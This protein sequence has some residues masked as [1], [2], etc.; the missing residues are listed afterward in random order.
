RPN[1]AV[2]YFKRP[3]KW[4]VK[5]FYIDE[6]YLFVT[7]NIIFKRICEPI[8][9]FDRHVIDGFMDLLAWITNKTS[10]ETKGIQSGYVQQYAWFYIMGVILIV[11]F[12]ICY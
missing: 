3:Y 9:W 5:K 1:K 2:S 4:A 10:E 6:V 7:N 12:S 11:L 8:A